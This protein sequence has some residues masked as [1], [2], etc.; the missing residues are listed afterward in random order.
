MSSALRMQE[1]CRMGYLGGFRGRLLPQV[2]DLG[3]DGREA[4][5]RKVAEVS[6]FKALAERAAGTLRAQQSPAACN[7][8]TS[9][10]ALPGSLRKTRTCNITCQCDACPRSSRVRVS[11][12]RLKNL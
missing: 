9:L 11:T 7:S 1:S 12:T 10:L 5:V 4:S 2:F 3:A 8:V 6:D